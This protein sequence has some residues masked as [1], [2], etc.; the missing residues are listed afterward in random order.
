MASEEKTVAR[1]VAPAR[2]YSQRSP[3]RAFGHWAVIATLVLGV[4]GCG[5]S[6]E[7]DIKTT[8]KDFFGALADRDG[9]KACDLLVKAAK[10]GAAGANCAQTV[11]RAATQA[12]PENRRE[13]A[14]KIEVHKVQINGDNATASAKGPRGERTLALKKEDGEWRLAS[15]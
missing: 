5:G 1:G 9:D 8:V 10:T 12:V 14:R 7:D 11:T 15:L 6:D 3:R 2:R 4:A 13:A